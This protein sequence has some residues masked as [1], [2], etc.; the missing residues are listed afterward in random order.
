MRVVTL[1]MLAALGL[2]APAAAGG[3]ALKL[4]NGPDI[5]TLDWQKAATVFEMRIAN[6][7]CEGLLAYG[8]RGESIPG[9]ATG[10]TLSN[11]GLTY[12]FKLRPDARWSDGSPVTADDFVAAWRRLVTPATAAPQAD[13]LFN[14]AN[15][16]A[17]ITGTA[18]PATLGVKAVDASTLVVQMARR[19][20]D[21]T[22][23]LPQAML[24]PI[25]RSALNKG[26]DDRA[27]PVSNGAYMAVAREPQSLVRLQK[28]PYFWDAAAV[29]TEI[30]EY[31][32]T[33]DQQ[34]ELKRFRTGDLHMTVSVP[35]GQLDAIKAEW[36]EALMVYPS[37]GV[38]YLSPNL[39]REPWAT[40]VKLRQAI[41]LAID[42]EMI[43]Q[44]VLRSGET[45]LFAFVPTGIP[46][47]APRPLPWAS[48]SQADRDAKA[49]QLL[50]EAGYSADKPLSIE[51]LHPTG[52][53][54]RQINIAVAAMLKQ[55]LGLTV[56]LHNEETKSVVAHLRA[57][58]YT[59]LALNGWNSDQPVTYLDLLDGDR[60]GFGPG[61]RNPAFSKLLE[62][63]RE[64]PDLSHM[65][66]KLAEAES[67][68]M[69]DAPVIPLLQVSRKLLVS[70]RVQGMQ[71][72]PGTVTPARFLR[73]APTK[74]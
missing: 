73:L 52:D 6:D 32:V 20:A 71:P 49:R 18:D 45:P 65:Y 25:H 15:A 44:K 57:R 2:A 9:V 21:F 47:Y 64:Q 54:F 33:E 46:G 60:G 66:D 14:L 29:P 50:A 36:G 7:I 31:H 10:W 11:D 38:L 68:A 17:I 23:Y 34:T 22:A 53:R 19:Q 41:S 67:L 13:K 27:M 56:T 74:P 5:S 3:E 28:N 43:S 8:A 12:I 39:S 63:A 26:A 30:V 48:L 59:D 1:A 55:K 4:G 42:R 16:Q 62:V 51:I 61:Y 72:A 24:C 70:T 37:A 69:A 40:Q 35:P 58:D